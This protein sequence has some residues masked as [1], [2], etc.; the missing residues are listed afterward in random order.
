MKKILIVLMFLLSS[1]SASYAASED[2]NVYVRQDVFEAKMETLFLRLHAEIENLGNRIDGNIKELSARIDGLDKR[3]DGLD[4]RIDGLDKRIDGLDK[5]IDDTHNF[6]Y[7][8]LVLLGAMLLMPT[9]N[10][11]WES[12]EEKKR[13]E[14]SFTLDDVKRLIAEA[15]LSRTPQV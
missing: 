14:P 13:F 2:M 15:M 12:R 7:Y 3:I 10:R 6:L 9:I 5:R 11:W 1:V 8:L 4:K